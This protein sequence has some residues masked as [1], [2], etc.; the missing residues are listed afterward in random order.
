MPYKSDLDPW[1]LH[2][3]N[4]QG[5]ETEYAYDAYLKEL[6]E[7]WDDSDPEPRNTIKA[8]FES[9]LGFPEPRNKEKAAFESFLR[10]SE[11]LET[12]GWFDNPEPEA[13]LMHASDSRNADIASREMDHGAEAG[14][15]KNKPMH[16][17][18]SWSVGTMNDLGALKHAGSAEY[19]HVNVDTLCD[20]WLDPPA[21]S[22]KGRDGGLFTG[23]TILHIAIVQKR[24]DSIKWLLDHGSELTCKAVGLF[25]QGTKIPKFTDDM[26][27]MMKKLAWMMGKLGSVHSVFN[28]E[29]NMLGGSCNFGEFPLSFAAAVG[30]ECVCHLLRARA[31]QLIGAALFKDTAIICQHNPTLKKRLDGL[32]A[33]DADSKIKYVGKEEPKQFQAGLDKWIIENVESGHKIVSSYRKVAVSEGPLRISFDLLDEDGDDKISFSEWKAGFDILDTNKDGFV[34][35]KEFGCVAFSEKDDVSQLTR[36][37]YEAGFKLFDTDGDGKL[38]K[39]E[40]DRVE[41]SKARLPQTEAVSVVADSVSAVYKARLPQTA[42]TLSATKIF[43]I[44]KQY[45]ELLLSAFL[46]RRNSEGDTALHLAV[47]FSQIQSIDWLLDNGAQPS[48]DMLNNANYTPMTLAVRRGDVTTFQH[49]MAKQKV[50]VWTYGSTR[51]SRLPLAQVDTIY[52]NV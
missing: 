50:Q 14:D 49:L 23:E 12:V 47:R 26:T 13:D 37:E 32:V 36:E 9:C 52:T 30:D 43:A 24:L 5:R 21:D 25:F 27:W 7:R 20:S 1:F 11:I 45:R 28:F 33:L 39:E 15:R 40:F 46:N 44:V 22:N 18:R 19:N 51:M 41:L 42:D 17:D 31:N 2:P 34:C 48:L 4:A 8:F 6:K 10:K 35:R 3:T 38:S 16:R 29:E